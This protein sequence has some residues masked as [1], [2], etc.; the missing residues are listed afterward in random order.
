MKKLMLTAAAAAM[1]AGAFADDPMV[2]D[3]QASVT[4]MYAKLVKVQNKVSKTQVD[5][6]Q[7]F[8]KTT[9]LKGYLIQD[10]WGATSPYLG[11]GTFSN[12]PVYDQGR[13]RAFLVVYNSGAEADVRAPKILPAVLEAKW[14]DQKF[15]HDDRGVTTLSD[16]IAEGTLFVGGQLI[17]ASY[18]AS[19]TNVNAYTGVVPVR[20]KLDNDENLLNY[21]LFGS[22]GTAVTL[23]V[24][25]PTAG[26][27]PR[28][29][30][31]YFTPEMYSDY[32]WTSM[33]LFGE[34]NGP[35][36]SGRYQASE[37]EINAVQPQFFRLPIATHNFAR[38]SA[39]YHDTWMNHAGI[40]TSKIVVGAAGKICCGLS[41]GQ[42]PSG[43]I[44]QSLAGGMKGGLYICTDNGYYQA[45][46][47]Y[48]PFLGTLWEDQFFAPTVD[49]IAGIGPVTGIIYG[50]NLYTWPTLGTWDD[51][52]LLHD[53]WV[54]GDIEQNT[55]DVIF[56]TWSIT[57]IS[58]FSNDK[59]AL[60]W[61]EKNR[62]RYA[63]FNFNAAND[64]VASWTFS[65]ATGSSTSPL[66][67]S[68]ED[69][70]DLMETIKGAAV[71]LDK[72]V[73]FTSGTSTAGD[74]IYDVKVRNR[75]DVP[76]LTPYFALAYGLAN[77]GR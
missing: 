43:V 51:I 7:K 77:Y 26:T 41:L 11:D 32:L 47:I 54:D 36:W 76:M 58:D 12:A 67:T 13:N 68:N 2:Y 35:Q 34:Y 29:A 21:P 33:Y 61:Q 37:T 20:P 65:T 63:D 48:E 73:R 30:P 38:E 14:F 31:P 1:A 3:Y 72:N 28:T 10:V 5:V 64:V 42:G 16:G 46:G 8:K 49:N 23:P 59:V 4:H 44:L 40:G 15:T 56:G 74:E 18:G 24:T 57:L 75:F 9:T 53:V 39:V 45:A 62:L 60:T 25:G 52:G 6:Y 55:T 19:H 27:L 70:E 66:T 17:N 71:K 50:N 22:S 69:Y